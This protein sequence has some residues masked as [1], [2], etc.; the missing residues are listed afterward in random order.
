M[1]ERILM[2]IK[3]YIPPQPI[4]VTIKFK[5]AGELRGLLEELSTWT[6]TTGW[7]SLAA[8]LFHGL[9]EALDEVS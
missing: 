5:N 4:D 1:E 9:N 2:E 7:G 3:H 6:P 8:E